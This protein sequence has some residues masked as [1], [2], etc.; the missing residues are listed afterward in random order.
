MEVIREAQAR[1]GE[2]IKSELERIERMKLDTEVTDFTKKE[3][4]VLGSMPGDGIGPKMCIR[5]R[6]LIGAL[7]HL[8]GHG[9]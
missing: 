5:D 8:R 7:I 4:I 9:P 2:L 3:K 1:F 6:F